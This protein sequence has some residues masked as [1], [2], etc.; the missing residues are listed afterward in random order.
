MILIAIALTVIR[1]A[2]R[3][4][5]RFCP[6]S[7]ADFGNVAFSSRAASHEYTACQKKTILSGAFPDPAAEDGN[8]S[9]FQ[10]SDKAQS[11]A[12]C[13]ISLRKTGFR[14]LLGLLQAIGRRRKILLQQASDN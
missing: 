5:K 12:L 9:A 2:I 11:A 8:T 7:G 3:L 6:I 14:L 4:I 1:K 10:I 13:T